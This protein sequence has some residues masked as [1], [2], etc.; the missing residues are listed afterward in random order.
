MKDIIRKQ[1]KLELSD[2]F[3]SYSYSEMIVSEK[4]IEQI[5]ANILS[6]LRRN[7]YE[8]S[9]SLIEDIRAEIKLQTKFNL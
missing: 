1:V 3:F 4:L 9:D 8:T 6:F 5:V 2:I 7:N